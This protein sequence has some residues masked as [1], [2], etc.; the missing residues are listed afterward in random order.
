LRCPRPNI[1][2]TLTSDSPAARLLLSP[3]PLVI[4]HRGY[5]AIAPENTLPSF[6]LALANGADVVELDYHHSHDDVPMAIHD[7]TLDRTTDARKQWRR[8]AIK[9]A[10]HTAHEIQSLDAGSWFDQRFEGTK[11][12]LLVEAL[13]LICDHGS[14]ALIEHKSGDAATCVQLLRERELINRVVVISFDWSYLRDFHE[15]EPTQVLGALGP[16]TRRVDGLKPSRR[17]GSLSAQWLNDL[18]GTGARLVVWN[19][20]VSKVTVNS[21]HERGLK[22]WIYTVNETKLAQS[23]WASGVD[24]LITNHPPL[25]QQASPSVA[26]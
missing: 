15:L 1:S 10:D 16:P 21:A 26:P 8:R 5:C 9:V 13:D 19:R 7:P 4:G 3:R 2:K 14:V 22:V 11:V 17:R 23:L 25:I 12:P 20:R 18:A 24:G 6:L